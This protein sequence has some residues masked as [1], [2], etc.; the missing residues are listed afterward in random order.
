MSSINRRACLGVIA[1][2]LLSVKVA[3]AKEPKIPAPPVPDDQLEIASLENLGKI[4]L[5]V[6]AIQ[7]CENEKRETNMLPHQGL[8]QGSQKR[9]RKIN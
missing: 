2:S 5:E 6:N 3:K 4:N 1:R 9:H 8:R 7:T